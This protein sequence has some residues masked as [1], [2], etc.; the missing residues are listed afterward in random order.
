M[1]MQLGSS[2]FAVVLSAC[3]VC[4]VLLSSVSLVR[5]VYVVGLR[6]CGVRCAG[7]SRCANGGEKEKSLKTENTDIK[8]QMEK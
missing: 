6:V 1:I 4:R 5:S 3:V 2:L 8:Y 7:S